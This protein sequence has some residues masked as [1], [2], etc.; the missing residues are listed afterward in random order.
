MAKHEMARKRRIQAVCDYFEPV[1]N[2]AMGAENIFEIA[3][4][5]KGRPL[6]GPAFVSAHL[7]D[8]F[9]KRILFFEERYYSIIA[10]YLLVPHRTYFF[11]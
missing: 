6:K 5:D 3:H 11:V 1:R 7:S 9:L 8:S 4:I 2:I 10:R